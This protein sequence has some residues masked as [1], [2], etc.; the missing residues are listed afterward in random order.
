MI[1]YKNEKTGLWLILMLTLG[2]LAPLLI[3]GA[4]AQPLSYHVFTDNRTIW[5]IPFFF[6]VISNVLFVLVGLLG[7]YQTF[8]NNTLAIVVE[9]HAAYKALFLGAALAGLEAGYYH[10]WPN[11]NTLIWDRI[12]MTIAIMALLSIALSEFVSIRLGSRLLFP[13]VSIGIL[14]VL[15]WHWTESAGHG[16]LRPYILVQYLPMFII[17]SRTVD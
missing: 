2:M 9:N 17:V 6:D 4:I 15:Y 7:L 11:N 10:L 16:D 8:K 12:P 3:M 5:G 1:L 13:L 14:S